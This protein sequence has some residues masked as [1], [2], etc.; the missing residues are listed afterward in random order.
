MTYCI[1]MR[2]DAGLVFLSDSRTNA[3]VDQV[4]TFRKMR[5]YENPGDRMIVLMSAG[6]LSISQSVVQALSEQVALQQRNIWSVGS[7]YDVAQLV[8]HAVKTVY[9]REAKTLEQ[10]GIDFN[11]SLIVGGQIRGEPCRLFQVYSPGNFIESSDASPYLQIGEAKYGKPIIDRV[12]QRQTSLNEAVKCALISMDATLRSNLSVGMPLDL[13]VYP[14]DTLALTRMMTIDEHTPYFRMIRE[15]WADKL[16]TVFREMDDP[17][18]QTVAGHGIR[19]PSRAANAGEPHLQPPLGTGSAAGSQAPSPC[20]V[21]AQQDTLKN[22][23]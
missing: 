5:I 23:Q 22:Q 3:G 21:L 9:Q 15:T 8:G 20:Q 17:A 19:P 10:F 2:L 14:A 11:T 7:M 6:N 12:L 13:L 16:K 18:W 1:G 4:S